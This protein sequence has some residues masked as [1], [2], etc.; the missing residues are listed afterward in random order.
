M[1]C[2][3][4]TKHAKV[5]SVSIS[6]TLRTS[7]FNPLNDVYSNNTT[8]ISILWCK[9][10]CHYNLTHDMNVHIHSNTPIEHTQRS[11]HIHYS[12][13]HSCFTT[14]VCIFT[15]II[16]NPSS[17]GNRNV[18]NFCLHS[19]KTRDKDCQ[20]ARWKHIPT[21]SLSWHKRYC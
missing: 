8:H 16:R 19:N 4:I 2:N 18:D 7:D 12:S 6:C 21:E 13:L 20:T 10:N 1:P 17:V 11:T 14:I 3:I 9:F 5:V 15:L